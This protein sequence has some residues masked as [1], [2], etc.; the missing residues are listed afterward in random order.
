[1]R[2]LDTGLR[3]GSVAL[4]WLIFPAIVCLL[5]EE[6]LWNKETLNPGNFCVWWLPLVIFASCAASNQESN[7]RRLPTLRIVGP[8]IVAELL[9]VLTT[10][11]A[12]H[13]YDAPSEASFSLCSNSA[14]F[15]LLFNLAWAA[16][17]PFERGWTRSTSRFPLYW[18]RFCFVLALWYA[19][20]FIGQARGLISVVKYHSISASD[21]FWVQRSAVAGATSILVFFLFRVMIPKASIEFSNVA[22]LSRQPRSS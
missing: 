17:F 6:Y 19:N 20:G 12:I 8:L 9:F 18:K 5:L 14:C 16:L 13:F 10:R 11:S 15:Y 2:L 3:Y 21:V 22:T 7:D 1:M 4:R